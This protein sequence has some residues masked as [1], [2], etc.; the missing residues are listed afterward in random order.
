MNAY[1]IDGIEVTAHPLALQ[2]KT[3]FL[4]E[5]NPIQKRRRG[6]RVCKESYSEPGCIVVMGR[7]YMHPALIAK[8]KEQTT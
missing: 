7:V 4:V 5:K 3:R 6:Y 2:Y 1:I 8:L